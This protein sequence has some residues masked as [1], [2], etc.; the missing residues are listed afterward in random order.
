MVKLKRSEKSEVWTKSIPVHITLVIWSLLV[1][2][3]LYCDL[4]QADISKLS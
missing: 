2:S 3:K 1:D 4:T